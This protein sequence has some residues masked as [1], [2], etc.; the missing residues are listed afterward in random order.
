MKWCM[1]KHS[2]EGGAPDTNYTA[3]LLD[4]TLSKG[5]LPALPF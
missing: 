1:C 3:Q 2:L 4:S 5:P